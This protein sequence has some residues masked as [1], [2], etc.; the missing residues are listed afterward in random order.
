M[1]CISSMGDIF[2]FC[3]HHVALLYV[4]RR[5]LECVM[6]LCTC[7][8]EQ[9]CLRMSMF[10][11]LLFLFFLFDWA[12]AGKGE[13]SKCLTTF[14]IQLE[15]QAFIPE[16]IVCYKINTTIIIVTIAIHLTSCHLLTVSKRQSNMPLHE[17]FN[18]RHTHFGSFTAALSLYL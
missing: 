5:P 16:L 7:C 4:V 1:N 8:H 15:K 13:K 11:L 3:R 17:K 10:L 12:P 14:D 9:T 18:T 6:Y 2:I